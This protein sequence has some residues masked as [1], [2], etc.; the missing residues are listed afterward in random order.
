[1]SGP[2]FQDT[3]RSLLRDRLLSAAAE[4]TTVSGWARVRM[5]DI[6]TR[7]GVSRQTVY[8][9]FGSKMALAEAIAL[10]ELQIHLVAVRERLE[11][12]RDDLG[13]AIAQA[14]EFTIDSSG[15]DPLL[16]AILTAAT[17]NDD[18]LPALASRAEPILD[19]AVDN[20]STNFAELWPDLDLTPEDLRTG[21]DLMIR[22]IASFVFIPGAGAKVAGQQARWAALRLLA[23][24]SETGE[25]FSS[26]TGR[27]RPVGSRAI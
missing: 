27:S 8:N 12:N 13:E 17:S 7:V 18:L 1:M 6:A 9:E 19:Y 14:V 24:P 2:R 10:R 11:A 25:A 22:I 5:S 23:G 4:L 15:K 16:R 21:V 26:G 3:V 20:I